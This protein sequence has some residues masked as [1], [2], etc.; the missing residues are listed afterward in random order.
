GKRR[1]ASAARGAVPGAGGAA[2]R[3]G[4]GLTAAGPRIGRERPDGP[5]RGDAAFRGLPLAGSAGMAPAEVVAALGSSD[6][7]LTE[8]EAGRRRSVLGPNA[9]RTHGA[10]PVDVFLRQ[11]RNPLLL[12]LLAVAAI[13]AVVGAATDAVIIMLI[14][15]LSV[16]LGRRGRVRRHDVLRGNR[17][18]APAARPPASP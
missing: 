11:L 4:G 8:D 18:A 17:A 13:S 16:G 10:R 1:P 14:S 5:P 6:E 3:G 12:L 2:N 9:L 15:G 7:G